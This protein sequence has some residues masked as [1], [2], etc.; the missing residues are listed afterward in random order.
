MKRIGVIGC[1]AR[2]GDGDLADCENQVRKLYEPGD[3]IISGGCP[4]GG[5]R[6]AEIIAK[7]LGCPITIYYPDWKKHGRSAGFVRN[8][9]IAA[10]SDLLVAVV[11]PSRTGGTEDT[12]RKYLEMNPDCAVFTV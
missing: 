11:H 9:D 5:D 12:I 8:T 10:N 4:R 6:F 1:R 7:T 3:M 2:N